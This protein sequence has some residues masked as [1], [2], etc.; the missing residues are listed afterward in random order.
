M[1][2]TKPTGG[3]V[4]LAGQVL[5]AL[6]KCHILTTTKVYETGPVGLRHFC[7]RLLIWGDECRPPSSVDAGWEQTAIHCD[8]PML[9]GKSRCGGQFL[10]LIHQLTD[11]AVLWHPDH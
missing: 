10:L 6:P 2:P 7:V 8:D 11:I 4:E 3:G 9:H 5:S 1:L